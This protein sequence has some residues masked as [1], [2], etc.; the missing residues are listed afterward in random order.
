MKV[1]ALILSGGKRPEKITREGSSVRGL[2]EIKGK[3]ML[4]YILA[5]VKSSPSI[6][7]IAL[8]ISSTVGVRDWGNRIEV[9]AGNG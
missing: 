6:D 1:D 2:I 9:V 7:R 4:D 5:A 8:V 3:P